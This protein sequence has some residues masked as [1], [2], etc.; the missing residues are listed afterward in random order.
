MLTPAGG[1][2]DVE[3]H[4]FLGR[5]IDGVINKVSVFGR[6]NPSYSGRLLL[7]ADMRKQNQILQALIDGGTYATCRLGVA[8]ANVIGDFNEI[9]DRA[10]REA[11]L[12]RSKRRKTASTSASVANSRRLASAR[13]SSTSAKCAG[14]IS[15]GSLSSPARVSMARAISS[16]VSGGSCRTASSA[17]SKSLVI[18]VRYSFPRSG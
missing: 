1:M 12:H 10:R 4:D 3:D 17:F 11:K 16:W 5:F 9:R 15:S 2:L 18:A 14:S 7:S 13:L 6:H 8:F